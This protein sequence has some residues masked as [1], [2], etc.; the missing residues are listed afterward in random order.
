MSG[1]KIVMG[2]AN[3][4]TSPLHVGSH[5]LA[6]GFVAAGFDV[7]FISDPISPLHL[8]R[9]NAA[10]Q[11]RKAIYRAGGKYD[12]DGKLWYYVPAALL[13]PYN[14]PFLR[15]RLL[16]R[17]WYR[18]TFPDIV[19][20]LCHHGFSD[21]D[22][23]YLDSVCHAFLLDCLHYRKAVYRVADKNSGFSKFTPAA[24]T[25]EKQVV[26]RVDAVV[27]SAHSLA[28]HVA[29][30]QPKKMAYLPNGVQFTHFAGHSCILPAEYKVLPRP[31]A[32]YVGSLQAWFDYDLV[33]YAAQALPQMSFVLIGP[34]SMA[35][36]RLKSL[37]NLHLLGPRPYSVLPPYLHHA[38][39]GIIPFD[40]ANYPELVH[41]V[42]PLKLYEYM[43]CGLPVVAVEWDEL[44]NLQ[45]PAELCRSHDDFVAALTR[46]AVSPADRER[47]VAYAAKE[48]WSA[49]IKTILTEMGM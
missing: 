36:A 25:Q 44:K 11:E 15:N 47:Y 40:V 3:Y 18:L 32:V 45:T 6:R 14:K 49:R 29:Q 5:H 28:V 19:R 24:C 35:R 27:Y 12:M 43:A 2:C 8:W 20:Q 17:H 37:P 16:Y 22:I 42:H 48:D 31:I 30:M 33:A 13:T 21:V 26:Q 4:W 46:L 7:A 10:L 34:D 38:D 39:V 41:S 9:N 1:K 23:V